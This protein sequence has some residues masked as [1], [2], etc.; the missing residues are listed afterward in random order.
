MSW[1][2]IGND[3]KHPDPNPNT[4]PRHE[5]YSVLHFGGAHETPDSLMACIMRLDWPSGLDEWET[6]NLTDLKGAAPRFRV[7]VKFSGKKEE[8]TLRGTSLQIAGDIG[9]QL[10]LKY[11]WKVDLTNYDVEVY[12][13]QSPLMLYVA[14]P[15]GL[16]RAND[17]TVTGLRNSMSW[18]LIK[19]AQIQAGTLVV[20]PM[21]GIGGLAIEA[22]KLHS[23]CSV[24]A[25]DCSVHQVN[26]L[27]EKL[28]NSGV[29]YGV[30][31]LRGDAGILPLR[32]GS[33]E[34]FVTDMPWGKKFVCDLGR[35]G[36]LE[37]VYK[38][39]LT[40]MGR[41]AAQGAI[42]SILVMKPSLV[43]AAIEAHSPPFW[44]VRAT[45][46]VRFTTLKCTI[47]VMDRTSQP[48]PH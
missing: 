25:I 7:T 33:I 18:G 26:T 10:A 37:E 44:S 23:N 14:M 12:V 35:Y 38:V 1:N 9:G 11:G 43:M 19:L 47:F 29:A 20:D 5:V 45:R 42:A 32:T 16:H 40:E 3:R 30:S 36:C 48:W 22:F 21:A 15:L 39:A 4:I 8:N 28:A 24:V 27:S 6:A 13:W 31:V 34:R 17:I 2:R 46:D 41:V